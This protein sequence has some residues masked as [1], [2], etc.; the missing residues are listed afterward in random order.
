M[1]HPPLNLSFKGLC[2]NKSLVQAA[3]S[4]G[5]S[6]LCRRLTLCPAWQRLQEV[7]IGVQRKGYPWVYSYKMNELSSVGVSMLPSKMRPKRLPMIS[8]FKSKLLI[9]TR[10]FDRP[11][12]KI[13]DL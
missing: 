9:L 13:L 7:S 11:F 6:K 1:E 10:P 8:M 4:R 12:K 3:T 5:H 2:V